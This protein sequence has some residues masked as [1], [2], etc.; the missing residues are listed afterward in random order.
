VHVT[1]REGACLPILA[2]AIAV[3]PPHLARAGRPD[4]DGCHCHITHLPLPAAAHLPAGSRGLS[5]RQAPSPQ[6]WGEHGCMVCHGTHALVQLLINRD[7]L[8]LLPKRIDGWIKAS[9]TLA[10][11]V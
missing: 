8:M 3:A 10:G 6:G 4:G 5:R 2:T 9:C 11:L 7:R 1:G